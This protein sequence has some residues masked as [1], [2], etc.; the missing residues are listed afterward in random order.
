VAYVTADAADPLKPAYQ[1][2]LADRATRGGRS[3]TLT[4]RHEGPVTSMAFSSDGARIVTGSG[5]HAK[6]TGT[7]RLWDGRTGASLGEPMRH[8]GVVYS[9]AFSPD[10]TRVVTGSYDNTARL[11]DSR[12]C[13]PLGN[14][15]DTRGTSTARSSVPTGPVSSRGHS[16]R[17]HGCGMAGTGSPL[18]QPMRH[19]YNWVNC[20][21]FSPDG[22]RVITGPSDGVARLWD[23]RTGTCWRNG[24]GM[25]VQ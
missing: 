12:T 20:V 5:D 19:P 22:M 25:I 9:V 1:Q 17:P 10:G 4:L 16:T 2:V 23:G 14:R 8:D 15:C 7:A 6:K 11:W 18:G 24:C 3:P 13:K 21:A